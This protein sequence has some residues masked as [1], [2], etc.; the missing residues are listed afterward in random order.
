MDL[1]FARAAVIGAI[2]GLIAI[3]APHGPRSRSVAV[4]RRAVG[5]LERVLLLF[6]V[7]STVVPI[8]W[9]WRPI[10]AFAEYPL[11]AI[12]FCVGVLLLLVG[13]WLF[14]RSHVDLGTNWSI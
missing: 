8:I 3:R 2:V 10:F 6:A 1:W 4:K 9:L 5:P 11:H 13:L 12:P 7:G 14:H